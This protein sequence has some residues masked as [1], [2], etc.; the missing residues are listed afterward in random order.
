MAETQK[1]KVEDTTLYPCSKCQKFKDKDQFRA[2]DYKRC[3]RC[4]AQYRH[5]Y[6]LLKKK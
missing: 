5:N 3:K 6:Y 2:H 1:S 4:I